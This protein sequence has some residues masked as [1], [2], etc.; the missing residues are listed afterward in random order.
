MQNGEYDKRI[1]LIL[2]VLDRIIMLEGIF[3]L[4]GR[5]QDKKNAQNHPSNKRLHL[6]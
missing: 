4:S 5:L 3:N 2:F 6:N 1:C